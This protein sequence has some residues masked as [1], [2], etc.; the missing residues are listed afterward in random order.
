[1]SITCEPED[2]VALL[3]QVT[4]LLGR[5]NQVPLWKLANDQTLE[6]L[7]SY[8]TA[9]A[10]LASGRLKAIAEVDSRGTAIAD[11]AASTAGWI[12][13]HC[14]E[15]MGS[16]KRQVSLARAVRTDYPETGAALRPAGSGWTPLV[17]WSSR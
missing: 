2:A 10:M 15:R 1:M 13:G 11:G 16:V 4:D 7:R 17:W 3:A 9:S 5:L 14:R 12:R 8:Q 6:L